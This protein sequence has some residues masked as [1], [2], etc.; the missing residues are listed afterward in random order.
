[1]LDDFIR[2]VVV[3]P[4]WLL[5]SGF[6]ATLI[7][8]DILLVL[9]LPI[10]RNIPIIAIVIILGGYFYTGFVISK[11]PI[12]TYFLL[13][14]ALFAIPGLFLNKI[15]G[16]ETSS[17]RFVLQLVFALSVLVIPSKQILVLD[18]KFLLKFLNILGWIFVVSRILV[19]ILYP[20]T[21]AAIHELAFI[22][23]LFLIP[24]L[25]SKNFKFTAI[26]IFIAGVL[27][28]INPRT[29][30]FLVFT[31][32]FLIPVLL[33]TVRILGIK[34][35]LIILAFSSIIFFVFLTQ[36]LGF[37]SEIDK[38]FKTSFGRNSNASF[39]QYLIVVGIVEFLK[40]PVYGK[41]FSGSNG[42]ST[43]YEDG[44]E[45]P[46]HNDLL[47]IAVQG[48][49]IGVFLF[50]SGILGLFFTLNRILYQKYNELDDSLRILIITVSTS[51]ITGLTT[52][53]FNPIVNSTH[54]GF[55][56]FFILGV[57]ILLI[58]YVRLNDFGP[59]ILRKNKKNS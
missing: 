43:K 29:T 4:L 17:L 54:T 48:G 52:I 46:L 47:E 36:I 32:T 49:V 38:I 23:P 58:R 53:A 11:P 50:L 55:F 57:S 41:Y 6:I 51:L 7:A 45:L 37:I 59:V 30:M 56:F 5:I 44:K 25:Y 3:W 19:L 35:I 14:L 18:I 24:A 10:I 13:F 28:L 15:A 20:E 39:R 2:K 16:E 21:S 9:S 31:M 33:L 1:M 22:M 8:A 34:T 27:F 26:S 40:S 12:A 42:Y